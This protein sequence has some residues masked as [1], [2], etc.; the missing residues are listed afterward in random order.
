[1]MKKFLFIFKNPLIKNTIILII[2]SLLV[3]V[4]G[5]FNRIVLTRLLGN[6]GISL[7]IICLPSIM[8]FMS[9]AGFSLNIALSK[10]VSENLVTKKYKNR[11]IL[12]KSFIIG[13]ISS[14]IASITLLIIAKPLTNNWLAQPD[15]FYP[16]ISIII[17]LPII[18][19]NNIIRGYYNGINKVN[20]SAYANVIEQ[21]SRIV[22]STIFLYIFSDKGIVFAVTMATISMGCGEIISLI[23][24]IIKLKRNIIHTNGNNNPTKEILSISFPT[25][26][27][28]LISNFTFFLEPII[29]TLALNLISFPKEQIMYKYSEVNAY[30][31]PLITMFC[32]ISTSIATSIAPSISKFQAQKEYKLVNKLIEKSLIF[33]I[34]PGIL[35]VT[36]L[37]QYS[38]EYMTLIYG[39]NIGSNYVKYF[40]FAFLIFYIEP[41][42]MSILQALG[43]SKQ[44]SIIST[45]SNLLKLLLIFSLTFINR[46]NYNSLIISMVLNSILVTLTLFFYLKNITN[47]K[48]QK[49]ILLTVLILL[50]L[51]FFT[52]EIIK[53][54]ISNYILASIIGG[55]LFL[56]YLKVLRIINF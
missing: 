1:M 28:R 31:I 40:S 22:I 43:K 5:L 56:I 24:S 50:I 52:F 33:S 48:F 53:A 29:F 34:I 27:S 23:F 10:I 42:I 8:L 44:L 55:L 38:D 39:T 51:T 11:T 32:F 4:L 21:I 20:L 17:F 30:A 45:F 54:S 6:E 9:I 37:Y 35:I 49:N 41:P 47:F 18:V 13:L 26:F 36:V 25:T 16:I 14:L 3:K 15:T 46:I 19:L 2:C 12:K 7:Y